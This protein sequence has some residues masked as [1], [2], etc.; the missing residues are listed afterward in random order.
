MGSCTVQRHRHIQTHTHTHTR[1]GAYSDWKLGTHLSPIGSP[2]T[3]VSNFHT[4]ASNW[5]GQ[6]RTRDRTANFSVSYLLWRHRQTSWRT[7]LSDP[8]AYTYTYVCTCDGELPHPRE[9]WRGGSWNSIEGQAHPG[10]VP[11]SDYPCIGYLSCQDIPSPPT[12]ID[13][14][15]GCTEEGSTP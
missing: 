6:K 14:W 9:N 11:D 8:C 12:A 3:W 4:K 10:S 13:W 5:S 7:S 1:P 2:F 15:T